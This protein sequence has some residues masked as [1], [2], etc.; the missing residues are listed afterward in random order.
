MCSD[1]FSCTCAPF[2]CVCVCVK[3]QS[4]VG[5]HCSSLEGSTLGS[6]IF[7][8]RFSASLADGPELSSGPELRKTV[9]EFHSNP[10]GDWLY[11]WQGGG[12][13]ILTK[14]RLQILDRFPHWVM[15]AVSYNRG[16][17]GAGVPDLPWTFYFS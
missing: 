17:T 10:S 8:Q 7:C 2:V 4:F 15:K 6:F 12:E 3:T 1:V 11:S 14:P 16:T 5:T 13:E 9:L